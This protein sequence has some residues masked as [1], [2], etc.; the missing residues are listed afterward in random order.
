MN[1]KLMRKSVRMIIKPL[2]HPRM[3]FKLRRVLL[4]STRLWQRPLVG[5]KGSR[6]QLDGIETYRVA[7]TD[8]PKGGAQSQR[9]IHILYLHGGGYVFGGVATH[10]RLV[11]SLALTGNACV[12]M[13]EYRLAPEYPYPAALNDALHCYLTLLEQDIDAE[14]IVIA[15]DS[16]GGGLALALALDL[17]ERRLAPA[18]A[19]MLL[20]PWVDLTLRHNSIRRNAAIDP[21]LSP[22]ALAHFA[23]AYLGDNGS[24]D[25]DLGV[26]GDAN[27]GVEV[28]GDV[29]SDADMGID[30]D[31][32]VDADTGI[33]VDM[34]VDGD[35]DAGLGAAGGVGVRC[36]P[37][38][39]DL[40]GLP[41]LII[42]VG[43]D[44][45]LLDDA[46]ALHQ[47]VQEADGDA[48]LQVFDD[49]WHVFQLHAYQFET[50]THA[51]KQLFEW[52]TARRQSVG[53]GSPGP[54]DG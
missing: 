47:A 13:P 51:V 27:M 15:G 17:K 6:L 7:P 26:D 29:N 38:S 28:D 39:A 11:D 25:I 22:A 49:M 40:S 36:S 48:T 16:A 44:E 52:L 8:W 5:V 4:N 3:P 35:V 9:P 42:Q 45:I 31:G 24:R 54:H 14:D 19:L 41:P 37:L 2:L 50:A 10:R 30:V 18:Q 32:D 12:W 1:P 34:G 23:R 46:K 33:D 53:T 43:S 21:M 20:S